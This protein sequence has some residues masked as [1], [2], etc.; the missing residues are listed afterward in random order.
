MVS[1]IRARS[2]LAALALGSIVLLLP[3][4]VLGA[5]E[6]DPAAAE[7]LF[8]QG[9]ALLTKGLVA[10][11]C[12]KLEASLKLDRGIGTM[13]YLADCWEREG[14]TASAWAQFREA[15]DLAAQSSD[16]REKVARERAER[17]EPSLSTLAI[18]VTAPAP[19]LVVERDGHPVASGVFGAALPIDPGEYV[20][21]AVAPG[22]QKWTSKVRVAPNGAHSLVSVP[23][24]EPLP[25]INT[26]PIRTTRTW[27]R[28]LGL[29]VAGVGLGG[30]AVGS[31]FGLSA[32][33]KTNRA[34][35]HC[36]PEGCDAEGL[37]V[38]DTANQ[39]ATISTIMFAAGAVLLAGGAVLFFTATHTS[40]APAATLA[41]LRPG[42]VF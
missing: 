27:Q 35:S 18:S 4:Q 37:A 17:I 25:P 11:A 42:F 32:I 16:S 19:S 12:P 39:H 2:Q 36:P 8:E 34:D 38:G 22:Y 24:L 13:L 30:I 7:A 3:A 26:A 41:N 23:S 31:A 1:R 9:R 40:D 20:V 15:A 10:E 33:A 6:R 14:R 28:V 5:D 21:T 29:G